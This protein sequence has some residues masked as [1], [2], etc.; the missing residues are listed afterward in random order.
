MKSYLSRK[1]AAAVLNLSLR[2]VSRIV[3]GVREQMG[4]RYGEYAIIGQGKTT[5]ISSIVLIDFLRYRN[6]IGTNYERPFDITEA[7]QYLLLF[8]E[9]VGARE[10]GDES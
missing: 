2:E 3:D 8:P 4:K 1:E 6:F 7:K 5:R 9:T 10:G